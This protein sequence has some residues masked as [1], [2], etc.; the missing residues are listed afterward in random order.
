[1]QPPSPS[2]TAV[3]TGGSEALGYSHPNH[4]K[5]FKL[6]APAWIVPWKSGLAGESPLSTAHPCCGA[7]RVDT[8][9]SSFQ[10]LVEEL[11]AVCCSNPSQ[12]LET[13]YAQLGASATPAILIKCRWKEV[14]LAPTLLRFSAQQAFSS[15]CFYQWLLCCLHSGRFF[16]C[17]KVKEFGLVSW[18]DFLK[19]PLRSFAPMGYSYRFTYRRAT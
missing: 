4:T 2:V 12:R 1:M 5:L 7:R 8:Q 11:R 18:G 9:L 6:D 16:N 10:V 14:S 15:A 3:G 17:S 19:L 13:E